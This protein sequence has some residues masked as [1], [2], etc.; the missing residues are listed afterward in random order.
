MSL[1][2]ASQ[3]RWLRAVRAGWNALASS[4]P[5]TWQSGQANSENGLPSIRAEPDVGDV[6]AHDHAHRGRLARPVR[7]QEPGDHTGR[8]L[9]GQVEADRPTLASV[10][11]A[12]VLDVPE[13]TVNGHLDR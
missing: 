10:E 9:E 7:A 1:V 12:G 2:S 3:R 6:Q 5:P 13:E 11:I 4:S 8:N